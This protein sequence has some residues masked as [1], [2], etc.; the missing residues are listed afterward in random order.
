MT[1]IKIKVM[2]E[3]PE[4][5]TTVDGLNKKVL[6]RTFVDVWTDWE[7]MVKKPSFKEFK[8]QLKGKKILRV[9]R[10]AKNVILELSEGYSLL[11]HMKMTGHLM[12]GK[13]R[14]A[15]GEWQ[16]KVPGPL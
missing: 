15:N 9:W 11:I 1:F 14:M 13:W 10:R 6:K 3:L 4:V 5:Q 16:P 7:K 2:P 12:V 8:H